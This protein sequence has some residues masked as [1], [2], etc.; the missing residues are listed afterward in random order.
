MV[1]GR[2][3]RQGRGPSIGLPSRGSGFV[4]VE[5]LEPIEGRHA[6]SGR[7]REP[8]QG[9]PGW[10]RG[11]ARS[12]SL[13]TSARGLARRIQQGAGARLTMGGVDAEFS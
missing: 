9:Y 5:V 10:A 13:R 11:R 6:V 2:G 4:H 7:D 8:E 12:F 1:I 3:A